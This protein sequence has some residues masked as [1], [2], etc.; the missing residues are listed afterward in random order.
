MLFLWAILLLFLSQQSN[1]HIT[2]INMFHFKIVFCSFGDVVLALRLMKQNTHL[3]DG[4]TFYLDSLQK[5]LEIIKL[6][7]FSINVRQIF[8]FILVSSGFGLGIIQW[9]PFFMESQEG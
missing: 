6:L 9:M 7:F 5:V 4:S 3:P 2:N 1:Q 8:I